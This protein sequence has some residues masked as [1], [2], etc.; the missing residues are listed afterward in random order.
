MNRVICM[1]PA[2]MGSKR[3]PKKNLRL[4]NGKPLISYAVTAAKTAGVFD[5]IYINSEHDTFKLIAEEM[6]VSFHKR[7]AALANDEANNDAFLS[8][9]MKHV[10]ADILVQ[11]L[12]TS[13]LISPE[14]IKHFTQTM[15]EKNY[16][17]LISTV[18]H[19]IACVY[20]GKGVN[21]SPMEPHKSSQTMTPVQSYATVLMAW[22]YD[23]YLKNDQRYGY[24]YHGADGNT[25]FFT[26]KGLSTIDV[27]NEADFQLAE[28]AMRYRDSNAAHTVAYYEP[29][30]AT[31]E[32]SEADV[33]RILD[34]DGVIQRDFEHENLPQVNVKEIIASKDNSKSWCHRVV[35]SENNSATLISQMPGEGNRMHYHPNWNEWWYIVDGEWEWTIEGQ[36]VTVRKDDM[37]FIEKNKWHKITAIG[38]KPAIRL[39]VSRA[40]VPHIYKNDS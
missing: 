23:S 22:T 15:H 4:L 21:F 34:R 17:T 31:T 36:K 9:F 16:D 19:Q 10:K 30:G 39:A 7:D 28:V 5:D 2:R 37:V 18:D 24:A 25:G 29:K 12:P 33:P 32:H 11:L 13:P 35:N 40:D 14:E 27:D 20:K 38:N 8:D 26:L 3:I 6:G 1:I